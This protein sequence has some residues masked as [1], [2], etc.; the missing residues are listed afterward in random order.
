M[1]FQTSKRAKDKMKDSLLS[2]L[3][4]RGNSNLFIVVL[5]E[6]NDMKSR[7]NFDRKEI[8]GT[9]FLSQS[10]NKSF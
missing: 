8:S 2:T 3:S 7:E 10:S 4:Y 6:M 5:D 9:A 1:E